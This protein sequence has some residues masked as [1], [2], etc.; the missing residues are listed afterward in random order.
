[1][2]TQKS[3]IKHGWL[4]ALSII[5]PWFLVYAIF[6]LIGIFALGGNPFAGKNVADNET[7]ML[8]TQLFGIFGTFFIIWLFT[9]YID[10]KAFYTVGF[11]K[12]NLLKDVI[13]GIL[14][15]FIMIGVG[16]YALQDLGQIKYTI[17]TINYTKIGFGVLLFIIVA[18][19]EELLFRGYLL[20]NF[21]QS[22]PRY[23]ALLI[24][25][26]LFAALHLGNAHIDAI[27]FGNIILAGFLLGISYTYTKSLWFPIALHFSWNFFQGTVF[28]YAVSGNDTYSII[29]QM[30]DADTVWNGGA[31]GFEA[32]LTAIFLLLIFTVL[33]GKYYANKNNKLEATL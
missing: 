12:K 7:T 14:A 28:G 31:F 24:S 23:W 8:V 9:K 10:K 22:V 32:S 20:N 1:M 4:R 30:R 2:T 5:I 13:L 25:S 17:N 33:I 19:N 18:I 3:F 6:S 11:V 15:G 26:L 29:K 27:G 21:L 16:F